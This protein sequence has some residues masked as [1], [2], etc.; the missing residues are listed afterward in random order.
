MRTTWP[1][2]EQFDAD[3]LL[4]QRWADK[5]ARKATAAGQ[6]RVFN[7]TL[8]SFLQASSVLS[9]L[10]TRF[11]LAELG[12]RTYQ[13][14]W[15]RCEGCHVSHNPFNCKILQKRHVQQLL[16]LHLREVVRDTVEELGDSRQVL[17]E[18]EAEGGRSISGLREIFEQG[19]ALENG[20]F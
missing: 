9:M 16:L 4:R 5:E 12:Y 18:L 14:R 10:Q 13:E 17:E 19:V 11:A 7:D 6:S 2:L 20:T 8:W 3:F 1:A 15:E